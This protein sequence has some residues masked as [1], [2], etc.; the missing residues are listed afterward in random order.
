MKAIYITGTAGSGKSL[1]T[2]NL[3]QWYIDHDNSPITLLG[4]QQLVGNDDLSV[5]AIGH[6]GGADVDARHRDDRT[7]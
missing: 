3:L 2:S 1:L 5:F 4:D 6:A 7:E